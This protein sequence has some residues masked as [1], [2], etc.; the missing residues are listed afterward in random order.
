MDDLN[1]RRWELERIFEI[2]YLK[3]YYHIP[4]SD[5]SQLCRFLLKWMAKSTTAN[6]LGIGI[7][8]YDG[9]VKISFEYRY[10]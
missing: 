7:F 10:V 6:K 3:K 9:Q 4:L 5:R 8:F 2:A 1:M